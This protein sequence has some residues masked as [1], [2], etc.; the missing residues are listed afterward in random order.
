[1]RRS[2]SIL[3]GLAI[4]SF[5]A[6]LPAVALADKAPPTSPPIN[7]REATDSAKPAPP[8]TDPA[9]P[10]AQDLVGKPGS[11]GKS[12]EAPGKAGEAPGKSGDAPGKAGEDPGKSGEAQGKAGEDPGKSG[13]AQGDKPDDA[14]KEA[15]KKA[16]KESR[17]KNK[18]AEKAALRGKV[19]T[20]LKGQP[21]SRA[22]K[23]EL[24]RHAR[25]LARLRRVRD[26]AEDEN[27]AAVTERVDKLVAK[28][29]ARHERW[30]SNY[31][32]KTGDSK[33]GAQ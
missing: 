32:A 4:L 19:T 22:M 33:G 16:R 12:G 2:M 1:M 10:G 18:Q 8:R 31:D 24:E 3:R 23:E 21:M 7:P 5:A 28:E 11:P 9:P 13:E 26:L 6:L 15:R 30:I 20:A 17:E 25:R 29:N 27:D 14:A